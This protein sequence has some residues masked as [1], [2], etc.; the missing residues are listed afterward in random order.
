MIRHVAKAF[1][2]LKLYQRS[3]RGERMGEKGRRICEGE[4]KRDEPPWNPS[5]H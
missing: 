3:N 1:K 4:Q 5:P 2:T